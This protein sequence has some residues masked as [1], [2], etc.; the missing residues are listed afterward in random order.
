MEEPA[1]DVSDLLNEIKRLRDENAALNNRTHHDDCQHEVCKVIRQKDAEIARLRVYEPKVI[2]LTDTEVA[3]SVARETMSSLVESF[4]ALNGDYNY[5]ITT[6][7]SPVHND[8]YEVVVRR[9]DKPSAHDLC[10]AAEAANE[11]LTHVLHSL[12][13]ILRAFPGATED[14]SSPYAHA[15]E[16]CRST[17]GSCFCG[18]HTSSTESQNEN[19]EIEKA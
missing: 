4:R 8:R 11:R 3:L 13:K 19:T 18:A 7:S 10:K 2:D 14:L 9:A 17:P 15:V 12:V 6:F 16:L 1:I 5:T